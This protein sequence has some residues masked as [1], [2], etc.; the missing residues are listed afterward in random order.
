LATNWPTSPERSTAGRGAVVVVTDN[1]AAG[2][3]LL[4]NR[5]PL[6]VLGPQAFERRPVY[7]GQEE[8][9][10]IDG[11][12]CREVIRVENTATGGLDNNSHNIGAGHVLAVLVEVLDELVIL[13]NHLFEAG[14]RPHL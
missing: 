6:H 1:H 11:L 8:Y 5:A 7:T 9:L 4:G 3:P 13:W 10:V 14:F 12:Q 2:K